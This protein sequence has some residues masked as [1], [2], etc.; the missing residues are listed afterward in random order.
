MFP[1]AFRLF[2]LC[3]VLVAFAPLAAKAEESVLR[4]VPPFAP[5]PLAARFGVVTPTAAPAFSLFVAQEGAIPWRTRPAWGLLP[6]GA[7]H[8]IRLALMPENR[9]ALGLALSDWRRA[10]AK[11]FEQRRLRNAV[12]ETYAARDFAP[13]W[14]DEEGRGVAARPAVARRLRAANEDGLELRAYRIPA[15]ADGSGA[16]RPSDEFNFSE[17]VAAY[18]AQASGSRIDPE[19]ISHLIGAKPETPDFGAALTRL[20]A[21]G[22]GADEMLQGYNPPHYGYRLLRDKLAEL[23]RQGNLQAGDA[24]LEARDEVSLD[25]TAETAKSR[26]K[27]YRPRADK[28]FLEGEILA[29]MERWRW[30]PRDLGRD[31]IEINIPEFEL[32]LV[33]GDRVAHRTRV[34]VGKEET[35]TPIFSSAVEEVIVNP[36]WNVPQSIISK[37]WHG[38]VARFAAKGWKVRYV[39][40]KTLVQQP[41][42]DGNA[43][44]QLKI[45]FPN[46]FS[47]YM[48]D[49]PSRSLFSASRRAF[50][51]GCMRVQQPFSLAEA[52]LQPNDGWSEAR[53]RKM[54]GKSERYVALK[55]PLP[56]HIEYFTAFVDEFG[57][58][59]QREDI[60]GYSAKVRR[61]LGV[62]G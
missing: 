8:P 35:P 54:I 33:R 57:R 29:N 45:I 51:H 26:A 4:R 31:H 52:I 20:A 7:D 42:G 27:A 39:G 41:P 3:A 58:L 50:S 2:G 10:P 62:G 9:R 30:L 25:D 13:L 11:S 22:A 6:E 53:L 14:V 5:A 18:V 16:W 49:T 43:L 15:A 60:Y 28:S 23:R 61:A 32:A 55:A 37:E 19:R 56:I 36:A 40:G 12:V 48:H 47:V 46:D 1:R 44:G 38:D 59:Q 21:A 34:I 24:V 17:A